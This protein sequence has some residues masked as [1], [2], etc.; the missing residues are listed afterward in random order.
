MRLD[1]WGARVRA[2]Q[3]GRGLMAGVPGAGS[4]SAPPPWHWGIRP[5]PAPAE[6]AP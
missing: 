6:G 2:G 1:T 3:D 5:G 4:A